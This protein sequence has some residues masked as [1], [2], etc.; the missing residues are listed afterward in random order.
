MCEEHFLNNVSQIPQ[1]RYVVK[2]PIKEPEMRKLGDSRSIALNRLKGL[3]RRFQYD[4]T[5]KLQYSQ[6]IEEYL[7]LSH[8]RR[9]DP[10]IGENS[11]SLY[12]PHYC[13]F[14]E[15]SQGSKL[16]VVFDASCASISGTSLN[17]VLMIGP[18]VQ[19]DLASVMLRFRTF[20]YV[21]SADMIKMYRQ[22][23]IDL[24]QACL[25]RILWRNNPTD[26]VI[27]Y[28]LTVTYGTSSA[29]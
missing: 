21:F 7:A 28:E 20:I 9:V 25:Q 3:K 17:V 15:T 5:L 4:P 14:K 29:S 27:T 8:M 12:L 19:P 1:G 24:S 6:F 23:L 18:V 22:I 16:R 11:V 2:L 26:N 13:V 10:P